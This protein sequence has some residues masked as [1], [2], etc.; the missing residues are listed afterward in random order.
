MSTATSTSTTV[1]SRVGIVA[2]LIKWVKGRIATDG[3]HG[4]WSGGARGM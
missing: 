3:D 4:V 2:T 1:P